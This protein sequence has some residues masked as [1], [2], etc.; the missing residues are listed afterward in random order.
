[1]NLLLT[2]AFGY[3]ES[4]I[5]TLKSNGFD[6]TFVQDEC[7]E[8]SMDVSKF[9][10][11]VCNNL[12]KYNDPEKFTSLKVVQL[13]SAGFDRVPVGYFASHGVSLFN[14]R[15]VYSIPMAEWAILRTLEIYKKASEFQ[16][17]QKKKIWE[18]HRDLLEING[19]TVLVVG[20]GSVGCECAKRFHAFGAKVLGGDLFDCKSPYI[21]EFV[22]IDS[23]SDALRRADITV[24]T[25]PLT[26]STENLFSEKLLDAMKE[27][28]VLI[29]VSRGGIINEE[30]L[31]KKIKE[32]KFLGVALDVFEQEPLSPESPLWSLQGVLLSPHNSF[33]SDGTAD[34][35]FSIIQKNLTEFDFGKK[36]S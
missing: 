3:T 29:N 31:V 4:Q 1:M 35:M 2:G 33:V 9:D 13:T 19:K 20:T 32:D 26:P 18:K 16:S 5:N 36:N 12:F 21:H 23:I 28:S 6:I 34:R 27:K 7:Q 14:A 25:L 15:G 22:H 11:V 24:L 30:D 10:A 17:Q 8:L